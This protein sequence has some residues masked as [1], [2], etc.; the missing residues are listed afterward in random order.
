MVRR[1]IIVLAV[2][3]ALGVGLVGGYVFWGRGEYVFPPPPGIPEQIRPEPT[4]ILEGSPILSVGSQYMS[5]EERQEY[6]AWGAEMESFEDWLETG[7][8]PF[9]RFGMYRNR[10]FL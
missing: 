10:V 4:V 3:V 5:E 9:N 8:F 2:V 1:W 7:P 6:L